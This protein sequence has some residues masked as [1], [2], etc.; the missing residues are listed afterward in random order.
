MEARGALDRLEKLGIIRRSGGRFRQTVKPISTS[1]D[2]RDIAIR[3][4]HRQNLQN[5]DLCLN[6]VGVADRDI[7]SITMAIDKSK[8]PRAK[9]LIRTFR[10]ELCALL[11]SGPKEEVFTLAIQLFPAELGRYKEPAMKEMQ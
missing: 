2:R 8:L 11:E 3:K 9:E 10:K 5:A 6:R 4:Y 7:S 1:E